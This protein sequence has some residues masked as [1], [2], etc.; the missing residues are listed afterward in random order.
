MALKVIKISRVSPA[1]ASVDPLIVPLSFFDLQWLKLNPTEQVFFYKLTESS[2]S[3][4]VFYSSILPK[5]ERSLSL[6]LTH[7]RLFTG[8]LKWD[9]Q[10]PKP[11][12]VVLSGD[13]LSL[14]VAETDA[15]FSRISG[16]GLRPE[17]ELRPL[18]PELPIYSDSGA[19]V[20]LQVTLFPKQG[21]CIGTTAHHVVLDGKT[22]EKF[23]KAWAHTCKHGTIPKILPTVLDRSVVNVPAGLEQKMLELLP[24]LT[25]DDK[26]NART[27]KL[28]PV[29]EIN[30]KD[31]VL[32]I[33]IEISPENIEKLKERAK[34]EST[35]A[36]LHLSTFVVTF[37][38][39]WTCMV[40]AR[41]GD[42]NRPVRFMYAADFRNRLEPPVPVTYF[43]TCVLAMDFYK[44][45]AKEFMGEDGF[46]N[47]VEILSDSVK[48]LASQG[49]ESTWKVYE[50]GTKTMKWGTQL[51]VVNGS[52]QIGMYETDFGWGRPI[53]TETMSIYKNDEFS[54]S[55][56][57]D[58][59]GGVEIGISLKKLEMDTFLSLFYKWIGN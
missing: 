16:R 35:R 59:I 29:K 20:S 3:R 4:D 54:M 58:G 19:V 36:E 2:S 26:E 31:N 50:E 38:H 45:K 34:K 53:H 46:V 33:T 28:P 13:T 17:L 23:N 21:F 40:K 5:L 9:S 12:L 14:T 11:H 47:T 56:R 43:G 8:H 6:I 32:R 15:D 39:V 1:T 52:N 42:P 37:A 7:F 27:L 51:L 49:V 25:E 24:Y 22:A 18:I 48:R 57:R 30:A 44:Y 55:K 10:D 41:S